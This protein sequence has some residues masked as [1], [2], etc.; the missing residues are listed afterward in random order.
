MSLPSCIRRCWR[1]SCPSALPGSA[2]NLGAGFALTFIGVL[3]GWTLLARLVR[4]LLHATPLTLVDRTLGAAFG[5]VRG[6]CCCWC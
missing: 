6:A 2:L 4:L 5:L 3:I 1:R